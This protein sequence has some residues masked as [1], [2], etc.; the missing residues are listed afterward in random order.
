MW[1]Q[2]GGRWGRAGH[3]GSYLNFLQTKYGEWRIVILLVLNLVVVCHMNGDHLWRCMQWRHTPVLS[4]VFHSL[5]LS[6]VII[7]ECYQNALE[8]TAVLWLDTSGVTLTQNRSCCN[9]FHDMAS[10]E[11]ILDP[12]LTD[13]CKW[14]NIWTAVAERKSDQPQMALDVCCFIQS[15]VAAGSLH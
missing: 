14:N 3:S 6:T 5:W 8:T 15:M 10:E 9:C 12:G 13:G 1:D 11:R 4:I 7:C 2:T